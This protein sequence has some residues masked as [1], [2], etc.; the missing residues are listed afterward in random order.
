MDMN[1]FIETFNNICLI[2]PTFPEVNLA[3]SF[4][5]CVRCNENP[6]ETK[7]NKGE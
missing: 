3:I 1:L 4:F 7:E 6:K 2:C 5:F